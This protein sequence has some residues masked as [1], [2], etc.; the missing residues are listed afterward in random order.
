MNIQTGPRYHRFSNAPIHRKMVQRK[1]T[2]KINGKNASSEKSM[3]WYIA[4]KND[5]RTYYIKE[6]DKDSGAVKWSSSR[7]KS[8]QF[9]TEHGVHHFIHAFLNNRS[10][11]FLIHAPSEKRIT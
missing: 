4:K 7:S 1:I 6:V 5:D 11:I 9:H 8:M 2:T 10:G 3:V